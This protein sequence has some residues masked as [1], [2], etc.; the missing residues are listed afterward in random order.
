MSPS[1]G[2]L[3]DR[4]DDHHDDKIDKIDKI[5]KMTQ[6]PEIKLEHSYATHS[7]VQYICLR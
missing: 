7:S 5:D 2:H 4:F 3:L 1:H 6:R